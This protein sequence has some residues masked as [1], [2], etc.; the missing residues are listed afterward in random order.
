MCADPLFCYANLTDNN[1]NNKV[2]NSFPVT[3]GLVNDNEGTIA[4]NPDYMPD[5]YEFHSYLGLTLAAIYLTYTKFSQQKYRDLLSD[6]YSV[7]DEAFRLLVIY[8]KHQVWK[9]KE[10]I[11]RHRNEGKIIKN[12]K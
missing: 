9:D 11:K 2:L 5:T 10:E 6:F 7:T 4:I 3:I 1:A 12:R 8:N